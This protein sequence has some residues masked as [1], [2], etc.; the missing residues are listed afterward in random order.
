MESNSETN[1]NITSQFDHLP[2]LVGEHGEAEID[3]AEG[4][5]KYEYQFPKRLE[6][7]E[8]VQFES[9]ELKKEIHGADIS[10]VAPD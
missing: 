6:Y 1:S 3:T 2:Y 7:D 10:N 4:P 8:M 5:V 9:E